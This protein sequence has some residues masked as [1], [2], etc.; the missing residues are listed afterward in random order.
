VLNWPWQGADN[1]AVL[2][3]LLQ[4][5]PSEKVTA[6]MDAITLHANNGKAIV[7]V[8]TKV[9]ARLG[10]LLSKWAMHI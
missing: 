5:S 8:N 6:L 4:V 7:F 3:L 10:T 9:R 2:A 1:G